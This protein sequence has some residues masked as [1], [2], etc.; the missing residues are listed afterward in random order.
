MKYLDA[1][2]VVLQIALTVSSAVLF[3]LALQWWWIS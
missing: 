1:L 3:A 2:W